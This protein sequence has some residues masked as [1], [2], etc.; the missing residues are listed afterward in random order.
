MCGN[1]IV[2]GWKKREM[3]EKGGVRRGRREREKRKEIEREKS[4]ERY[5]GEEKKLK[6][7][8]W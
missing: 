3:R 7:E 2:L 4:W 5:R 1:D 8:L 6:E